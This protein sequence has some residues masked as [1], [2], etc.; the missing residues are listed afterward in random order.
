[1]DTLRAS[2]QGSAEDAYGLAILEPDEDGWH[3]LEYR[4]AT[5]SDGWQPERMRMD[6]L[7]AGA[8]LV[9]VDGRTWTLEAVL[10]D[11]VEA[12]EDER[13]TR[14]GLESKLA[15]SEATSQRL[16]EDLARQ[17][18]RTLPDF[19][20]SDGSALVVVPGAVLPDGRTSVVVASSAAVAHVWQVLAMRPGW[21]AA[22][23]YYVATYARPGRCEDAKRLASYDTL[24]DAL[25]DYSSRCELGTTEAR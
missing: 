13:H 5:A 11:A 22:D 12:V 10:A 20:S 4:E 21:H 3:V 7:E 14:S 17:H 25:V 2:M 18:M 24:A 19:T 15:E 8:K 23:T 9:D 1:V 16:R 6:A